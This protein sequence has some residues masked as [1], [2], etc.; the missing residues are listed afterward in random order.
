MDEQSNASGSKTGVVITIALLVLALPCIVGVV[1]FGGGAVMFYRLAAS[2]PAANPDSPPGAVAPPAPV[3]PGPPP[4]SVDAAGVPGTCEGLGLQDVERVKSFMETVVQAFA[5]ADAAAL[6]ALDHPSEDPR[7]QKN[8][9]EFNQS[10]MKGGDKVVTW[11]ARPYSGPDWEIM[12]SKRHDPQP[13]VWIDVTLNKGQRDYPIYFVCSP[14][15][16]GLL[17]TCHHVD[18]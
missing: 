18:R 7:G 16:E 1:L 8:S 6:Q 4:L 11:M 10:L 5:K 13:T 12:K 2:P 17:R 15:Q 14:N 3:V 9:L